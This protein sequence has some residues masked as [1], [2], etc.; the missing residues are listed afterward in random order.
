MK[1]R[2]TI[3][4]ALF[5]TAV[6]LLPQAAK[7][8]APQK[9]SYQTVIRDASTVLI[10][11][12]T[13]GIQVSILQGSASGAAVFVETHTPTTN[14]NGLASLEIGTGTPVTGTMAGIDWAAGPY[15]IKTET[16][17]LGGTAYSIVGTSQLMSVPYALF[18]ANGTPGAVGPTGANGLDGT[19]GTDGATGLTGATGADG[20]AGANGAVGATGADGATGAAGSNGSNG[21]T[22]ATGLTGATGAAGANGS[23][24]ATGAT[25]LTGATGAAGSNGSNGAT[26]A[27]GLTGATG[28]AGSNG[29]NGATGA[30]GLTGATGAAGSNGSNGA[31]GA[32]GLTGATG[33]A[34]SNGSNGATGATGLTGATG[35]AGSNGSNGATGA[36]G[37][38]GAT[39]AAGSNGSNGAT[40]ATGLT[41]ATGAA[42]S[43]GSNGATGAT[44]ATGTQ[45][46][47]GLTG[48]TGAA[49]ADEPWR[50][51][52]GTPATNTSTD[53]NFTSGNVGIGTSAVAPAQKLEVN[54]G[55]QFNGAQINKKVRVYS[56]STYT[57]AADDH[58]IIN[59]FGSSTITLPAPAT[60]PGRELLIFARAGGS[61]SITLTP[62]PFGIV[63]VVFSGECHRFISTGSEWVTAAGY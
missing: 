48:P 34:G 27:T 38:T 46:P 25:G 2:I 58:L 36:T 61:Y 51:T 12:T 11:S 40:G 4:T 44:G 28:A 1:K 9:M 10:T 33:A 30:T 15:F 8:Q 62:T 19:N 63:Q 18:S 14:A 47:T 53:I 20:A 57:V 43:N 45:G 50:N 26:G 39:G 49:P 31:T 5:L 23:N 16:D 54:G 59:D 52:A 22:G 41:G 21:A 7:A 17:P 56:T 42:G 60:C 32:T 6:A 35:A 29:S 55:V 24:G 37:L 3:L 13:V